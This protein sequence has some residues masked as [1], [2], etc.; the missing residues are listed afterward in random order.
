MA[1]G[2]VEPAAAL[3]AGGVCESPNPDSV[4]FDVAVMSDAGVA[5]VLVAAGRGVSK[6]AS[7]ASVAAAVGW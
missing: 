7:G 2:A 6:P 1:R 4:V 3:D 5:A